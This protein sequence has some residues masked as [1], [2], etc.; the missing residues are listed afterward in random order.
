[1]PGTLGIPGQLR[2]MGD[3]SGIHDPFVPPEMSTLSLPE[4]K[5]SAHEC[6]SVRVCMHARARS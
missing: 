4:L 1:M 6:V 2:S 3:C 5:V